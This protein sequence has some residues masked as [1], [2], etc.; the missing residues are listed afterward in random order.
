MLAGKGGKPGSGGAQARAQGPPR[1]QCP[2]LFP[3]AAVPAPGRLP[4][5][6]VSSG[7]W[8][9]PCPGRTGA[10]VPTSRTPPCPSSGLDTCSARGDPGAEAAGAWGRRLLC[11][12]LAGAPEPLARTPL[13][14]RAGSGESGLGLVVADVL[15]LYTLLSK[16]SSGL[17]LQSRECTWSGGHRQ[18]QTR[19]G[20][21][22]FPKQ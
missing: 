17:P 1:P 6:P 5:F 15:A 2:Y 13:A 16:G 21:V 9:G 14:G 4:S 12:Q 22:A 11:R 20:H 7:F 8:R 18:A 10:R 3:A 19:P